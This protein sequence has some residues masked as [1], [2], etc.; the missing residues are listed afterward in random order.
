MTS[1]NAD[2]SQRNVAIVAGFAFLIMTIAAVFAVSFVFEDLKVP[3]DAAATANNIMTN[4]LLFRSGIGSLII[5]LICD[6]VVAWALYVFLKQVNKSLS[7]LAAWLRLVYATFIGIALLNFVIVLLLLSGADYLT[8]LETDQL[9]AQVFL[10]FNAFN[11]IWALG[12][13]VFGIHLFVLGYLVFKSGYIPGILGILII[14]AGF[15]YLTDSFANLFLSNYESYKAIIGL[16]FIVPQ[17]GGELGLALW[18]LF[19]GGKQ[20]K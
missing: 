12:I 1:L 5:V 6:A 2:L 8:V 15:G 20:S 13:I 7:L 3:G 14:I 4:E 17:V 19:R 11:D 16:V 10:F 9:H 18:L